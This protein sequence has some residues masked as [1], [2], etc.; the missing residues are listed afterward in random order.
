MKNIKKLIPNIIFI[1]AILSAFS[2]CQKDKCDQQYCD[3]G[4]YCID[5]TCNCP[6]YYY[7]EHCEKFRGYNCVGG[8]CETVSNGVGK[9]TTLTDCLNNCGGGNNTF[10][11]NCVNGNCF[12]VSSNAQ[13]QTKA[14]CQSSCGNNTSSIKFVNNTYTEIVI[15]INNNNKTIPIGDNVTFTGIPNSSASGWAKTSGKTTSG[16]QIGELLNWNLNYNYPS[17]GNNKIVNLDITSTYFF[18]YIKNSGTHKLN[19]LK[20]NVNLTSETVDNILIPN[21]GVKY[22]IGYYKAFSNTEIRA[23]K[24]GDTNNWVFWKHGNHFTFPNT[25]NQKIELLNN[26]FFGDTK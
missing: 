16:D 26:N 24:N 3:N 8:S 19:P 21:D 25:N 23:Y 9:Y 12:Y 6:D 22:S 13:Y 18:L 5:G 20:V 17:A 15:N 7:G 10:G 1:L 14:D 4:G 11:F 2:S